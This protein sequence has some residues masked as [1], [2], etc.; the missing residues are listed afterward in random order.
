MILNFIAVLS[1][2][3]VELGIPTITGMMIDQGILGQDKDAL[4][5]LGFF[6][7]ACAIIGGVGS[8]LLNYTSTR[9]ST[10]MTRDIRTDVFDK[11]QR[12]SHAQYNN[13]GISSMITRIVNDAY[14]LT[15]FTQMILRMGLITPIMVATSFF[16]MFNSS[17]KLAI[18][19]VLSI[20]VILLVVFTISKLSKPLSTKQQGLLDKINRITRENIT[21]VRVIRAFR[22]DDYETHRFAHENKAYADTSKK[23]FRLMSMTEPTFFF[24]LHMVVI[25]IFIYATYMIR[26]ASFNVGT[27]VAFLE[28]QF[29]ALYSL[30]LFATVFIMY[31]RAQVSAA[32]LQE[33]LDAPEEIINNTTGLNDLSGPLTL[34]FKDVTFGYPDSEKNVLQHISFKAHQGQMVAFIGSTGS[35]KSSIMNLMVRFYDTKEGSVELNGVDVKDYELNGLRSHFGFISQRTNLFSGS[36]ADN[37]R[38]GKKD[39]SLEQVIEASTMAS[40]LEFIQSKEQGFDTWVSEGGS[41]LSGGQKQRLS[42]ARALVRKPAIYVFDDSFSAL[43]YKTD[44]QIR[45][46]IKPITQDSIVFV[47]AQRISSILDADHIIVL[48]EGEIVGQG[49]HKELMKT[50]EVYLEIARSQFNE[51]EMEIYG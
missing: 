47:V 11:T 12:I 6:L 14:Q 44:V 30:M 31:P 23:L 49:T 38:Y 20:P 8:V 40:A 4:S 25:V 26:D 1:F 43:D 3:L 28:Y 2:V 33:I 10:Y 45:K 5:R 42:I 36:I 32:R 46:N 51:K 17:S 9:F 37:I 22:S 16:L 34:E 35:G 41:N 18:I 21:G 27:L 39:A 50:C 24:I 15:L 13:L 19:N 48:N 29:H 7:F